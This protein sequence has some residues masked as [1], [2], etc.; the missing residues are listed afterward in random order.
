LIIYTANYYAYS[1]ASFIVIITIII[2]TIIIK[3]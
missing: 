2:M 1:I 3:L